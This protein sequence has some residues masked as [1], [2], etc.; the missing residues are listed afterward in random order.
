MNI[1]IKL[2]NGELY[3][4]ARKVLLNEPMLGSKLRHTLFVIRENREYARFVCGL[5][6]VEDGSKFW[7]GIDGS[8]H[9]K[10]S[11]IDAI[12]NEKYPNGWNIYEEDYEAIASMGGFA[13][14]LD[15]SNY[16]PKPY[17]SDLE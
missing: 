4:G 15:N 17:A 1:D 5:D 9:D 3:F 12:L 16:Y 11:D 13:D 2:A 10:F 7:F 14:P 6:I 8:L